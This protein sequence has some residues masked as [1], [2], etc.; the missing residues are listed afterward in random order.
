MKF[1]KALLSIAILSAPAAFAQ[2]RDP[3]RDLQIGMQGLK[4]AANNPELLA[5]LMHDLQVC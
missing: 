3:M 1:I 5:Q 2:E 4:E